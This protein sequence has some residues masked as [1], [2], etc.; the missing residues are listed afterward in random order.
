MP[1]PPTARGSG[2]SGAVA[3]TSPGVGLRR[4]QTACGPRRRSSQAAWT[5]PSPAA[6]RCTP[7]SAT[8]GPLGLAHGGGAHAALRCLGR[9]ENA[10]AKTD[11]TQPRSSWIAFYGPAELH[12]LTAIVPD[13]VGHP[14]Q[15]EAASHRPL[16]ALLDTY[17]LER[18]WAP[19]LL[20]GGVFDV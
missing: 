13:V 15:A 14:T 7:P 10:L 3:P 2:G 12:S 20:V 9:A 6:A 18:L 4:R 19:F 1:L 8:P 5:P 11:L 16:A 17:L